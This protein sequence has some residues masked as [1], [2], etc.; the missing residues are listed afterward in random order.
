MKI[1][2]MKGMLKGIVKLDTKLHFVCDDFTLIDKVILSG[3]DNIKVLGKS[4]FSHKLM[5]DDVVDIVL[6]DKD[7]NVLAAGSVNGK[8][9]INKVMIEYRKIALKSDNIRQSSISVQEEQ[10]VEN[11]ANNMSKIDTKLQEN[12]QMTTENSSLF[13]AETE[14]IESTE[15]DVESDKLD[16]KETDSATDRIIENTEDNIDESCKLQDKENV[17]FD[18]YKETIDENEI[19]IQK[20]EDIKGGVEFI[21]KSKENQN[22]GRDNYYAQIKNDL[23]KFFDTYPKNE[24]L[25]KK[26]WGS[27]WVKIQTDYDYSVGVIFEDN[28][29]SIIAYAIPYDDYNEIDM[30]KLEFGEWLQIGDSLEDKRGYFVYYQNAQTGEMILNSDN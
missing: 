18:D 2:V 27:K 5:K 11:F 20:D 6:L 8:V 9:N 3:K 12:E 1:F 28:K 7:D 13:E 17:V 10:N 25:E 19:F 15:I 21:L 14:T 4:D 29:P 22:F 30:E 23:N 16:V 26:V 24:E